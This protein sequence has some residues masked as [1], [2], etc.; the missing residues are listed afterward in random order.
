MGEDVHFCD[1]RVEEMATILKASFK[2]AASLE[3]NLVFLLRRTCERN[4]NVLSIEDRAVLH[5][6]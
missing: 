1:Q 3:E 6:A 2:E 4:S 5:M